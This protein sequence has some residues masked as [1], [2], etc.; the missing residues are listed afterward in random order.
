MTNEQIPFRSG[1]NRIKWSSAAITLLTYAGLLFWQVA[2]SSHRYQYGVPDIMTFFAIAAGCIVGSQ[3]AAIKS[4]AASTP[5]EWRTIVFNGL[6]AVA[7]SILGMSAATALVV[8]G[9]TSMISSF[10]RE[11]FRLSMLVSTLVPAFDAFAITLTPAALTRSRTA[12]FVM[13]FGVTALLLLLTTSTAAEPWFTIW[14]LQMFLRHWACPDPLALLFPAALFSAF[15]AYTGKKP[16]GPV[17]RRSLTS[18]AIAVVAMV[19]IARVAQTVFWLAFGFFHLGDAGVLPTLSHTDRGYT[20]PNSQIAPGKGWVY[21]VAFSRDGH[22]LASAADMGVSIWTIPSR[23]QI[24]NFTGG[25]SGSKAVAFSPDGG[26]LAIASG[27]DVTLWNYR[28]SAM[29]DQFAAHIGPIN[30]LAYSPDG[31]LLAAAGDEGF[32]IWDNHTHKPLLLVSHAKSPIHSATFSPNGREIAMS[33]DVATHVWDTSTKRLIGTFQ[34]GES[35]TFSPDG[36]ILATGDD[37]GTVRLWNGSTNQLIEPI[38]ELK[39]TSGS[40]DNAE[41]NPVKSISFFPDGHKLVFTYWCHTVLWDL[42]KDQQ[43]SMLMG[44]SG[45]GDPTCAVSPDGQTVA[46][47]NAGFIYLFDV[48]PSAIANMVANHYPTDP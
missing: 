24:S 32:A 8:L 16:M 48:S 35:A 39:S 45:A 22:T 21:S 36:S 5:G 14:P 40:C 17:L 26:T 15:A 18:G 4:N 12:A 43:I 34:G 46:M 2:L 37:I 38:C 41:Y 9:D 44:N 29:S 28:T 13:G 7:V 10:N 6:V 25:G 11:N 33:S 3:A 19:I 31:R 27:D 42:K 1:L 23:E 30:S 20:S 47:T